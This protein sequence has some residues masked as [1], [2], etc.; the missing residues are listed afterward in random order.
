MNR[1]STLQS[2]LFQ[3]EKLESLNLSQ[4]EMQ[5]CKLLAWGYIKKE[6]AEHL[7]ISPHTVTVHL[8]NI[9]RELD[10][11]KETDLTRW[12]LFKEYGINDNP[13]KVVIAIL[14]LILSISTILQEQ[15]VVRV[16]RSA[17]MRT[18]A[19]TARPARRTAKVYKYSLIPAT[20]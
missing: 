20:A 16:F 12:Y 13:F 8:K 18:I 9:Y 6:I 2:E 3:K 17:P 15:N 1:V 11:H 14:F 5:I 4:R 19:R 7:N 10:I